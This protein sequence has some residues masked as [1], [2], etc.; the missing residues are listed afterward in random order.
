M[1]E[2]SKPD[3]SEPGE[4][5]SPAPR[6]S[7]LLRCAGGSLLLLAVSGLLF[8]YVL[9]PIF[10]PTVDA[11][12]RGPDIALAPP[13]ND[14]AD[15]VDADDPHRRGS[16]TDLLF[17]PRQTEPEHP[18]DPLL[19][20]ARIG[21]KRVRS[22]VRDYTAQVVKQERIGNQLM[23]EEFMDCKVRHP[24]NSDGRPIPKSV[25]LKF[26]KPRSLA[27]QEAIWVEGRHQ[28]KLIGHAAGLLNIVRAYLD[29]NGMIAMRGNRHPIT[30]F[31]FDILLERMIETGQQ[32]RHYHEV[33]IDID[34]DLTINGNACT[35]ITIT[36][37][38][39]RDHFDLHIAK[40]YID[41]VLNIPTGYEGYI[42]PEAPGGPPRL[43]EKYFYQ[44]VQLNVGLTDRDFDPDN[45]QYDF[46]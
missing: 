22:D 11:S 5:R 23:P 41:D 20:V 32:E 18:L 25:Y 7:Y 21:L 28:G 45:P 12:L 34:R 29:P 31:G 10:Q 26:L 38:V 3:P 14:T 27:G 16:V 33:E 30:E 2:H 46:P 15:V 17:Q 43:L 44:E 39:K 9:V 42:W 19:E 1:V 37:P 8:W 4:V 35:L 13:P 36:H 6:R 40:I 24:H